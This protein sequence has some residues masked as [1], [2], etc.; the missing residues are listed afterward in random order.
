MSLLGTGFNESQPADSDLVKK[1]AAVF[2]DLK[3]RLKAFVTVLFN[4]DT[5]DFKD[6][7]IRQGALVDANPDPSGTWTRVVVNAKGLVDSGDNPDVTT[8]ARLYRTMYLFN[9]GIAPDGTTITKTADT[10]DNGNTIAQY[11]FTTPADVDRLFVRVQAPGGGSPVGK[12]GGGGGAYCEGIVETSEGDVFLVWVG[13]GVEVGL[14]TPPQ[15]G[16][17]KFEFNGF[18]YLKANAGLS[19]STSAGIS[20]G[21]SDIAGVN[22]AFGTTG[23]KGTV[24]LGGSAGSGVPAS[25]GNL[26]YGSGAQ[27]GTTAAQHG[28][29]IVEYWTT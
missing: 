8:T 2:R 22:N 14:G 28:I 5:G 15:S 6:G 12:G 7:V 4:A 27:A 19:A 20:G 3:Q 25:D 18:K 29:V 26:N 9:Q 13:E 24:D 17:S 16:I 1:G 10:D 21:A 11:S 23:G